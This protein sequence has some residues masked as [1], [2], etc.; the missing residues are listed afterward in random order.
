[1][2]VKQYWIWENNSLRTLSPLVW[3]IIKKYKLNQR[4]AIIQIE[5]NK[6]NKEELEHI[7]IAHNI[8]WE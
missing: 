1:M 5:N 7:T 6:E 3:I 2:L 4:K 8:K